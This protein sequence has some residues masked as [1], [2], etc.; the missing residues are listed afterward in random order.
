ML[1]A[2]GHS[3]IG[4]FCG[5]KVAILRVLFAHLRSPVVM[6]LRMKGRLHVATGHA[7]ESLSTF[8]VF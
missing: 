8:Q 2:C 4:L 7:R 6:L 3:L 5:M 1:A